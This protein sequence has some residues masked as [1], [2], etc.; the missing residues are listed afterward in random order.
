MQEQ[1]TLIRFQF[2]NLFV[3][4]IVIKLFQLWMDLCQSAFDVLLEGFS[5]VRKCTEEGRA[6]MLLDVSTLQD[7]LH[8]IHPCRPPL[9]KS[10]LDAYLLISLRPEAEVL[11]WLRENWRQYAYRHL[12]GLLTQV[13]SSPAT[14]Q[15]KRLKEATALLDSLFDAEFKDDL[16][17]HPPSTTSSSSPLHSASTSS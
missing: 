3:I 6:V 4:M 17:Q 15:A 10:H 1:V 2:S 8:S 13:C 14:T 12:L 9:G 7:A 5:R 11:Q 16:R